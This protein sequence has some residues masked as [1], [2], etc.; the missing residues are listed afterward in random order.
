MPAR[1][2]GKSAGRRSRA[3][4]RRRGAALAPEPVLAHSNCLTDSL[5][6]SFNKGQCPLLK[7]NV[8]KSSDA[9]GEV[10]LTPA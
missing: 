6:L 2:M 1:P 8:S 4:V 5:L 3:G 10:C 7:D 9:A